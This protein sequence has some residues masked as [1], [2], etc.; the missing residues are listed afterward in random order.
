MYKYSV[1]PAVC[2]TCLALLPIYVPRMTSA[3]YEITTSWDTLQVLAQYE[4]NCQPAQD[5]LSDISAVPYYYHDATAIRQLPCSLPP[6]FTP[7]PTQKGHWTLN[8]LR[9][10]DVAAPEPA[11]SQL[12]LEFQNNIRS[13]VHQIR[14]GSLPEA[15]R[16]LLDISTWL[17]DN[18]KGIGI[19]SSVP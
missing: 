1:E 8:E 13:T 15:G 18:A 16:S 19:A 6:D 7:P 2:G 11:A 12:I 17:V 10:T 4:Q 9:M 3:F 14:E 5:L